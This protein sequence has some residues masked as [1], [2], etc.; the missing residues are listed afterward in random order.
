MKRSP[1][2]EADAFSGVDL[3]FDTCNWNCDPRIRS[4]PTSLLE[5]DRAQTPP[6]ENNQQNPK[7]AGTSNTQINDQ[8]YHPDDI[9]PYQ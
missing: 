1:E 9:F 3:A 4:P 5:M 6:P 8:H 2:R 7:T